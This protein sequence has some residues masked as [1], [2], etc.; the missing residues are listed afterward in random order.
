[1]KWY[2]DEY[3]IDI[4]IITDT[5]SISIL[6]LQTDANII[7]LIGEEEDDVPLPQEP[8]S[9]ECELERFRLQ[10]QQELVDKKTGQTGA[11]REENGNV[12]VPAEKNGNMKEEEPSLEEQVDNIRIHTRFFFL[13]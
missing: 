2:S 13:A 11:R 8:I 5:Y 6:V 9:I 7:P 12:V 1:M 3:C 4:W 10:W